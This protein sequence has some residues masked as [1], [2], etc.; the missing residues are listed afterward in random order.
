MRSRFG[1]LAIVALAA[2]A[3]DQQRSPIFEA[4]ER[5]ITVLGL[6]GHVTEE[7]HAAPALCVPQGGVTRLHG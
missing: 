2:M 5:G 6:D 4:N 1:L 7:P 3:L